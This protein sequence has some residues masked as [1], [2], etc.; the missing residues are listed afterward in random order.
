MAKKHICEICQKELSRSTTL[1]DHLRG[2]HSGDKP[3]AC[4]LCLK[5]FAR[6]SDLTTHQNTHGTRR[7]FACGLPGTSHANC[8]ASFL[9]KRDLERHQRNAGLLP[10]VGH[11]PVT[12]D[13]ANASRQSSE[14][15]ADA[16]M[17]EEP[18]DTEAVIDAMP[19]ITQMTG[20]EHQVATEHASPTPTG[21]MINNFEW[22]LPSKVDHQVRAV[23]ALLWPS[24][25]GLLKECSLFY[26]FAKAA[27]LIAFLA[28]R[29]DNPRDST[30]MY[31]LVGLALVDFQ[32]CI[33]RRYSR[34]GMF[35]GAAVMLLMM[36]RSLCL[37]DR[38]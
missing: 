14:T 1:R 10:A 21:S 20:S 13:D 24:F 4:P 17:P 5:R 33:E 18:A 3:F 9:R 28:D 29:N 31:A 22:N 6:K 11:T 26:N 16:D 37:T 23:E 34:V 12:L 30:E 27:H 32:L 38:D 8:P 36:V 7:K 2:V 35:F 19:P 15:L 25:R